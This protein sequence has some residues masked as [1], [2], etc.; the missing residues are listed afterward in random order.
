MSI[1]DGMKIVFVFVELER[2]QYVLRALDKVCSQGEF[3]EMLKRGRR[4]SPESRDGA[5]GRQISE[6]P[7][8]KKIADMADF[9]T[10]KV[11]EKRTIYQST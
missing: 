5:G 1:F 7:D 4:E 10:L 2:C 11:W 8:P 9:D 3:H 6:Y